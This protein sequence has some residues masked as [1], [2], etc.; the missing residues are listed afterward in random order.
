MY[1]ELSTII[2]VYE[3]K[4]MAITMMKILPDA[5]KTNFKLFLVCLKIVCL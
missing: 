5:V 3:L 1:I 4:K 2:Q